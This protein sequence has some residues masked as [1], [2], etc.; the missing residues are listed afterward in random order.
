VPILVLVSTVLFGL[1]FDGI[2]SVENPDSLG[3]LARIRG[4]FGEAN[5]YNV[6]LWGSAAGL[7]SAWLLSLA[8]RLLTV[9]DA[10]ETTLRGIKAMMTACLV[11]I[12]AWTLADLCSAM[13]TAGWL[14]EQV[15]FS[16]SMLPCIVFVLAAVVGF[17]TGSSWSTMAILVPLAMSYAA[18]LGLAEGADMA[19]MQSVLLA[20][21]GG[22]LAG[23]VFGDHCS[24]ISDTTVMSSMAAGCDHMDHVRTQM[25]YA[26]VVGAVAL[27]CGYLPAGF[28]VAPWVLLLGS[29]AVLF[30]VL[31][32]VGRPVETPR[33]A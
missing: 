4:A 17:S 13:N 9:K 32:V 19:A 18:E 3:T 16:F 12:M 15:T 11:L 6:L 21:I 5:S 24:P 2:G 28:G 26:L 10:S 33:D 1:Y 27:F 14:I 23:A 22:V 25:P 7:L 8:Q 30:V 29:G 20:S 31:G